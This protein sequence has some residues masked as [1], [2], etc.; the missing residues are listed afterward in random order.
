[1]DLQ[2]LDIVDGTIDLKL[3]N[4]LRVQLDNAT[5]SVKSQSLLESKKLAG[6]K[7]SLTQL[8]V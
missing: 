6:I 4:N 7:N 1:M 3:K 5:V 2:Q 8:Q